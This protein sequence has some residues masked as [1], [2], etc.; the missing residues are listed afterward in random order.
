VFEKCSQPGAPLR[1]RTVDLLLTMYRSADAQPQVGLLTCQNTSTHRHRQ[2]P[3]EPPQAPFATQS[4]TQTDLAGR[5][6]LI[7]VLSTIRYI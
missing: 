3:G 2:A 5:A 4:A 1:N 7:S 6:G